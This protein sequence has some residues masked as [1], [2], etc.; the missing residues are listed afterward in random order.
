MPAQF[1]AEIEGLRAI[2]LKE[3]VQMKEFLVQR[4]AQINQGEILSAS[5]YAQLNSAAMLDARDNDDAF[6]L[7]WQS[8]FDAVE[9]AWQAQTSAELDA[10]ILEIRKASFLLVGRASTQKEIASYVSDDMELLTKAQALQLDLPWLA[11]L[12]QCYQAGR[13]P[14]PDSLI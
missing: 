11:R 10:L 6:A 14:D 7:A 2:S 9:P 12:W 5:Y 4:L 3:S 1:C 13:F 8:A